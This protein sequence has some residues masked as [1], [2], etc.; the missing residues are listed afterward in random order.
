MSSNFIIGL[1]IGSVC[2]FPSPR[3]VSL[4]YLTSLTALCSG[5]GHVFANVLKYSRGVLISPT[6]SIGSLI[7]GSRVGPAYGYGF[8]TGLRMDATYGMR[9]V[10]CVSPSVT[11]GGE[12]HSTRPFMPAVLSPKLRCRLI[13]NGIMW[14]I[15]EFALNANR[16]LQSLYVNLL[17]ELLDRRNSNH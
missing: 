17:L 16:T 8:G 12:Y 4:K 13:D 1:P 15:D 3:R 6:T 5:L 14:V 9:S 11:S 7:A 10:N 2:V